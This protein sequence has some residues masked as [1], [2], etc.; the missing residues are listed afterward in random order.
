MFKGKCFCLF[1]LLSAAGLFVLAGCADG[2]EAPEIATISTEPSP[3]PQ[4]ATEAITPGVA[5]IAFT[6]Q[7]FEE[8]EKSEIFLIGVDG[9]GP[10]K[11]VEG[12][13]GQLRCQSPDG[14][15]IVY[16]SDE[17]VPNELFLYVAKPDGSDATKV[18][19]QPAELVWCLSEESLIRV[20]RNGIA[21]TLI[22]HDLGS[23]QE[24][25]LLTDVVNWSASPDGRRI[26]FVTGTDLTYDGSSPPA[27]NESLEVVDP[28]TGE[29][30][31]LA[32]PQSGS[33][34]FDFQ[35]S[36]DGERIAYL[37]GPEEFRYGASIADS[38][39][40]DIFVRDVS[41]DEATLVYRV[42][43]ANA[44]NQ[45]KFKWSPSGD[46]LLV[47]VERPQGPCTEEEQHEDV[48]KQE[49]ELILVNVETGEA[50]QVVS[51][52]KALYFP[53]WAPN[54]DSFAYATG[55][56]AYLESVN[57]AVRELA[58]ATA[59]ECPFCLSAFGWSPDGRY[60]GLV[61]E[62]SYSASL[63]PIIAV[64]DTTTG[65]VRTI[66]EQQGDLIFIWPQWWR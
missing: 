16:S 66:F 6:L 29:R 31:P 26:A 39:D 46:W 19:E 64:L 63:Q 28:D 24:T 14:G 47:I 18:T 55:E 37:V 52:N 25:T 30:R 23:G 41:G 11:L 65:D 36:P 9:S 3:T 13:H 4:A 53:E 51:S 2:E 34:Y 58:T 59:G 44:L 54:D 42:E 1:L 10:S 8:I 48:C 60:I 38:S 62:T 17:E 5:R 7:D 32:G 57:G 27:G 35:W 12:E 21:Q 45:P 61:R 43:G 40:F 15:R 22:L 56:A 20:G 49:F 50:R 33:S